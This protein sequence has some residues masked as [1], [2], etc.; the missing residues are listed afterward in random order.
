MAGEAAEG[1]TAYVT[2]EPCSHHG[3]TPPC[4]DALISAKVARVVVGAGDPDPRVSGAG[5]ARLRAAGITVT[6]GLLRADAEDVVAGFLT[7]ITQGRPLVTLKLATT[8]D[9]RIATRAGESQWI[10]G[11]AARRE[12]HAMRGRHDAVLVGVGTVLADDP[13]LTCRLTGYK[14]VPM[15]RVIADSHLRTP[16]TAALVATAQQE[17]TWILLRADTDPVRRE[18]MAALDVQLIEVPGAEAGIDLAKALAALAASGIN[19][20]LVEGGAD[21]AASLLREDLVDRMAWF[22]APAVMG[23]DGWPASAAFAV[24]RLSAMPR[25]QRVGS[26]ALGDDMLTEL[27]R[28]EACSPES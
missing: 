5:L 19:S 3:R 10:T 12:A 21:I 22:H 13:R 24:E 18:R 25:F 28:S 16:P 4:C 6:D 23:G 27:Q 11:P 14:H 1:A 26:R 20:V 9:G 2:L 8:L 15:I 17:P 7:R